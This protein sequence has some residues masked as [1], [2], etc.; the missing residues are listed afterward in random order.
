MTDGDGAFHP[1]LADAYAV[2][3]VLDAIE[4]SDEIGA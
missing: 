3:P 4:R 2:Q 1:P